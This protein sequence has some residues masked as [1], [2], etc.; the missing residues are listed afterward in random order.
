ME[1]LNLIISVLLSST[2]GG[3]KLG[4]GSSFADIPAA[5]CWDFPILTEDTSL[6]PPDNK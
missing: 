1:I 6:C 5:Y 2:K 4:V 3:E